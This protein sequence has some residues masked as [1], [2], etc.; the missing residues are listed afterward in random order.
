MGYFNDVMLR[1]SER[2]L[3]EVAESS[4]L[5]MPS[6]E[7]P[8]L[9][10]LESDIETAKDNAITEAS[11]PDQVKNRKSAL[12]LKDVSFNKDER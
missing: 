7:R 2:R 1:K 5:R 11:Y 3:S 4:E 6:V 10:K 8:S 9:K 12:R